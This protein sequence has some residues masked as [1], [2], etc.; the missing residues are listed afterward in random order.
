MTADVMEMMVFAMNRLT[1]RADRLW[2]RAEE[3]DRKGD[4]ATAEYYEIKRDLLNERVK[5][6]KDALEIMGYRIEKLE[7]PEDDRISHWTIREN[8]LDKEVIR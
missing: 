4:S 1:K 7:D 6:M 8:P 5:G 3:A 2:S